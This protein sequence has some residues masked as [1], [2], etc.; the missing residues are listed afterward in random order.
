MFPGTAMFGI[1]LWRTMI[2]WVKARRVFIGGWR[3]G[4]RAI[5]Q[6]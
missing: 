2:G 4:E 5:G 6:W 1:A 3:C